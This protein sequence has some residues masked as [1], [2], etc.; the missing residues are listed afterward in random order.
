MKRN[1]KIAELRE[2]MKGIVKGS[3]DAAALRPA[4]RKAAVEVGRELDPDQLK[5]VTGSSGPP[6]RDYCV[7]V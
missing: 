3:E 7:V 2:R 1:S 5:D 6:Y 4:C